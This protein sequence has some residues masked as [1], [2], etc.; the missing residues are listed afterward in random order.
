MAGLLSKLKYASRYMPSFLKRRTRSFSFQYN[1]LSGAT[2]LVRSERKSINIHAHILRGLRAISLKWF[3]ASIVL[4]AIFVF[5]LSFQHSDTAMHEAA[6]MR[7]A[8][9]GDWAAGVK[10][11]FI[12]RM[13]ASPRPLEFLIMLLLAPA[14][15]HALPRSLRYFVFPII[16]QMLY[17]IV[18]QIAVIPL[19]FTLLNLFSS[20]SQSFGM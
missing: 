19:E 2:E 15:W 17:M 10:S 7:Q 6:L 8:R 5:L 13:L 18:S 9:S 16:A 12:L 20:I 1:P 11:L 4:T 14:I 3:A